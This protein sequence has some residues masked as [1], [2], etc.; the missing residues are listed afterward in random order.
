MMVIAWTAL[1]HS[2]FFR[3]KVKPFY[4]KEN[5]RYARREGDFS[6]WE[7][8]EC[9]RQFYQSDTENPVRKNLEFFIRLRNKIEHKSLPEID[10][11]IFGECQAMLL[12]F[13]EMIEQQYGVKYCI[14][15]CLSF[16][17]QLFPSS[18]SLVQAIKQNPA[19]KSVADFINSYRSSISNEIFESS[20]FTFKAFLIQVTNHQSK[21][22]LPV[23]FVNYNN[24]SES[25]KTELGKFVTMV[26]YREVGVANTD[27]FKSGEVVR[28]VQ[29]AL[30]A[31]KIQRQNKQIDKFNSDTHTRFWK[32]VKVRP[33]SNST[34]PDQTNTKY[35]VYDKPHKDYLYTKAWVDLLIKKM[36]S[37]EE[38]QS[39]YKK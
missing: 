15:E 33:L 25:Q 18:Q 21:G 9:L 29:Q 17:L 12:N 24:L 8:N 7:L 20:R 32:K 11:D 13:D 22:V 26:K 35:C 19:T 38:Y 3:R 14:R 34:G 1:F 39:L 16:S 27:L 6:Y 31:P 5:G 30:G 28:M 37:E 4:K 36:Q 23:Q 10:S 2:V